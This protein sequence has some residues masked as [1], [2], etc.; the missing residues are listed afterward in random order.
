MP[1]ERGWLHTGM[2]MGS[3][4]TRHGT[5]RERI[6]ATALVPI[7]NPTGTSLT[8]RIFKWPRQII[9]RGLGERVDLVRPPE[10]DCA[11]SSSSYC[12]PPQT[13]LPSAFENNCSYLLL[14]KVNCTV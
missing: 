10:S 9:F 5:H 11:H 1:G 3:I 4:S 2:R 12:L 8:L 6:T 14:H 7:T 13:P